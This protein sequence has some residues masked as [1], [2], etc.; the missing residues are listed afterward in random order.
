MSFSREN[1]YLPSSMT[2]KMNAIRQA[3]NIEFGTSFTPENFNGTNFY[4]YFYALVQELQKSE[5]LMSEVF[6]KLQKYIEITNE[7]I[8]QPK[9]TAEGI[10]SD[11]FFGFGYPCSVKPMIVADRGKIHICIDI[12][13]FLED[14]VAPDP[15]YPGKRQQLC[16]RISEITVLGA[17]TEGT[18]TQN[19]VLTNGQEFTYKYFLPTK[20]PILLRLTLTIS[21]NNLNIVESN[22]AI[23]LK[24]FNLINMK[25]ALGRNFEPQTYFTILDA[26]WTS[27]VLLEY[28][29][30]DGDNWLS[31]IYA[32]DYDEL[33]T[34]ELG[35]ITI[36]EA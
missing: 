22:D 23:R 28:S 3:I 19:I 24:L 13:P 33:L 25:Y 4:K 1:G 36:V 6:V 31:S 5:T 32:A 9:N 14:G 8:Q 27:A 16:R 7:K 18:E 21:Q 30:D 17:V 20:I 35:D 11:I 34:F 15:T 29:L 10:Q 12:D 2:Q 26:P